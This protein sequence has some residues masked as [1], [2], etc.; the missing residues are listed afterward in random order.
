MTKRN[1]K[2]PKLT[3][4]MS[5]HRNN[6][7]MSFLRT[8]LFLAVMTIGTGSAWGAL[9]NLT[10][11][12]EGQFHKWTSVEDNSTVVEDGDA[13]CG[14]IN[15]N[16]YLNGDG[17][18][19]YGTGSVWAL[20]YAKLT[21]YDIIHVEGTNGM[22]LRFLFNRSTDSSSDYIEK[23]AT[24]TDGT[25]DL[26]LNECY[27][28]GYCHLNVI[29]LR[30]GS[31]QITALQA[32]KNSSE[33]FTVTFGPNHDGWGTVTA[34]RLDT[35]AD[36]TSGEVV[37]SGTRVQ[38][39][40]TAASS[41]YLTWGWQ[42]D[43][44]EY[45]ANQTIEITKNTNITHKFTRGYKISAVASNGTY[46][47]VVASSNG[48]TGN[49]IHVTPYPYN[50]V[51][52]KA[53]PKSGCTLE[54]WYYDLGYN[55]KVTPAT[56]VSI[57]GNNVTFAQNYFP[58]VDD[59]TSKSNVFTL[60]AKFN[61]PATH[62][63]TFGVVTPD[64]KPQDDSYGTVTATVDGVAINTGDKVEE[65]KKVVFTATPAKDKVAWGWYKNSVRNNEGVSY[66]VTVGDADLT[67]NAVI[68]D[69][70]RFTADSNEA[71]YGTVKI[72]C[73]GD[74]GTSFLTNPGTPGIKYVATPKTGA[75]FVGWFDNAECTGSAV[76]TDAEYS[77][78][79]T[80][81]GLALYA[82]YT[83]P[84]GTYGIVWSADIPENC[85]AWFTVNG[86][87]TQYKES[88]FGLAADA[89]IHY[90]AT[91]VRNPNKLISNWTVGGNGWYNNASD[92][93]FRINDD[94]V[95]KNNNIVT[96]A[97]HF[98]DAYTYKATAIGGCT[99]SVIAAKNDNS[100]QLD[101]NGKK[102]SKS[103]GRQKITL[104]TTPKDGLTFEGWYE[105]GAKIEAAT[106]T[107]EIT[108]TE[109]TKKN[110]T[111]EARYTIPSPIGGQRVKSQL[112]N[113]AKGNVPTWEDGHLATDATSY[114]H[115]DIFRFSN[116]PD[117]NVNVPT[118]A[119]NYTGIRFHAKA[120]TPFRVLVYIKGETNPRIVTLNSGDIDYAYTWSELGVPAASIGNIMRICFAGQQNGST[121][122]TFSNVWV[123]K[124][125]DPCH[126]FVTYEDDIKK[127]NWSTSEYTYR[128]AT[129]EGIAT[130]VFSNI[131]GGDRKGYTNEIILKE[132]LT[133]TAP[134][135]KTIKAL[136]IV[137]DKTADD[138]IIAD[139][140][141][142]KEK[143]GSP[144]NFIY[145]KKIDNGYEV[146]WTHGSTASVTI[147]NK[148]VNNK[149]S[150]A[151]IEV[152]YN[153]DNVKHPALKKI[154]DGQYS[155]DLSKIK[156]DDGFALAYDPETNTAYNSE[157]RNWC[158]NIYVE[159]ETPQDFST[160]TNVNISYTGQK[161]ANTLQFE[162]TDAN[163]N[164][165]YMSFADDGQNINEAD[166]AKLT[167]VKKI[168][169]NCENG[170]QGAMV[171]DHIK[172]TLG[173]MVPKV[174]LND[175]S[176]TEYTI[177]IGQVLSLSAHA[178]QGEG[179]TI[180][181]SGWKSATPSD[182]PVD[183]GTQRWWVADGTYKFKGTEEGT[184]YFG[185]RLEQDC[186]NHGGASGVR[187]ANADAAVV[188]VHVVKNNIYKNLNLDFDGNTYTEPDHEKGRQYRIYVPQSV[189]NG[190]AEDKTNVPVVFSLH[191]TTNDNDP[192]KG[193]V[194]NFNELAEANKFIVVYPNG[195]NNVPEL[196]GRGWEATGVENE[197]TKFFRAIIADLDGNRDEFKLAGVKQFTSI[198][199]SRIYMT[200][201]SN[202]GMMAYAEANTSA[203]IFAAFG[204]ISG[205]PIN[206][207]HMRHHNARPVP[208]IHIHGTK[209]TFVKY[210]HMPT[211]VDN[212]LFRNGLSFTHA[213]EEGSANGGATRYK[214]TSY[215]DGAAP[216]IYYEIGTGSNTGDSGMG[217]NSECTIGEK[218][219]MQVMWEFL[220]SKTLPNPISN[221]FEFK[222]RINTTNNIAREHGW[223]TNTSSG[224]LAQYG[225]SGGYT[226]TGENVY[227]TIHLN[228]G[229]HSIQF[230]A[231][232]S[233][234]NYV[235]VK[236]TKL[237]DFEAFNTMGKRQ[238]TVTE[239]VILNNVAYYVRPETDGG[240]ISIP[241]N[242]G[243]GEYM[244]TITKGGKWDNTSLED[245][246]IVSG[247]VKKGVVYDKPV[248]TDFGGY[249]NYNNRLF[250][251]WNF[252]LSDGY[253]TNARKLQVN[254]D[255]Q[256]DK[257]AWTANLSNTDYNGKTLNN[258][259]VVFSNHKIIGSD[260]EDSS[261]D[262]DLSTYEELTYNGSYTQGA[263]N[264]DLIAIAAGLKFKAP[265]GSVKLYVDITNG[266]VSGAHLVVDENVKM[267]I[268]Y[269][270]NSYRNDLNNFSQ[271]QDHKDDFKNCMHHINR[272]IIYI[273][274]N[275]G[276]IWDEWNNG[277]FISKGHVK[278][279]CID[280]PDQEL[281]HN[282]GD[283]FV[284]G[285]NYNKADYMGKNGT[286]CIFRFNRETNIDRIGVNRNL[287]YSFYT[288]YISEL[289]KT[290][291]STRFRVVGSPTGQK[292]ANDGDTWTEYTGAIAMTYGGWQNSE[293]GSSYTKYN[294]V[295]TTD[296]WT[297]LGVINY[298]P[299]GDEI[300]F[301]TWASMQAST[302]E[303]K[304]LS[305]IDG[306]PVVALL[307]T[308]ARSGS[309]LPKSLAPQVSKTE[310]DVDYVTKNNK[311]GNYVDIPNYTPQCEGK[312]M[313]PTQSAPYKANVTP[314]S[315][316]SRGG[317]AKFEPSIPGVLNM[318]VVQKGGNDYYIADEFGK[319]VDQNTIFSRT[320]TGQEINKSNNCY[321][322]AKTDYVKHSL[323][324]E[325]GKTYYIFSN[326]AGLGIAGFYFEPY[327]NHDGT[328]R[329]RINIG[330][331]EMNLSAGTAYA[332]PDNVTGSETIYSP[333]VD[334]EGNET[335]PT[336][337]TIH[338]SRKAVKV[339]LRRAFKANQWETICL[340]YSMNQVQ[341]EQAFGEGTRVVLL[342]DIQDREHSVENK[343]TCTLICHENQDIIAGYPYLIRPTKAAPNGVVTIASLPETNQLPELVSVSS[344]G[345]NTNSYEDKTYGGIGDYT[346]TGHYGG[347]AT[348]NEGSYAVVDG[349]LKRIKTSG[350]HGTTISGYRAWIQLNAGISSIAL[351]KAIGFFDGADGEVVDTPT[352]IDEINID[353]MLE[354]NGIFTDSVTVYGINGQIVRQN[355]LNLN[356]L[357]K[358][359]YIVNGKKFIVK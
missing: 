79:S 348:V 270:E 219:S 231:S 53:T 107:Y 225:E 20:H 95:T 66:T 232:G 350:G 337:Y 347:K 181:W 54:G 146:L 132:N 288:E 143:E 313:V 167:S 117:G 178:T 321:R 335:D 14:E 123:E 26:Y 174:A 339:N 34:K 279:E 118:T 80:Q 46:G 259:T 293:G 280:L 344:Q 148:D 204:S 271:P 69:G 268:P 16:T 195:R 332:L 351:A 63:V 180:L 94:N 188:T 19:V 21:G 159:F 51:T 233:T 131:G 217:H 138:F 343:V 111:F 184:F 205:Y 72:E 149:A 139:D 44:T 75:T 101:V 166:R 208:F 190:T 126:T 354:Q 197:D 356:D 338:Y 42:G 282:G 221:P 194:Q 102:I 96:L 116:V 214:M 309:L 151:K 22:K 177:G 152:I 276:S 284:N 251:Q 330:V 129:P 207:M 201:F 328:E 238:A 357:P 157:G 311:E 222:A 147:S 216:Y 246:T 291:P 345:V 289:G 258:G 140:Y 182:G 305:A 162:C 237:T 136:K 294:D 23:F 241:F 287:I 10:V 322:I 295:A 187:T 255:E 292:I 25:A 304:S 327:V 65:G 179:G 127:Y 141:N 49:D 60:W 310:N 303:T 283:E 35:N 124:I 45:N 110:R 273:A 336:P 176:K 15:L 4:G 12:G 318:N 230:T 68:H 50:G 353:K 37:P 39:I 144:T 103:D 154:A 326:T 302:A 226:T 55:N 73:S 142:G 114:N 249:F 92:R 57:D 78:T 229:D 236:V 28:N 82:K 155:L 29:K 32:V 30:G 115:V 76:S 83:V 119:D 133:I 260:L 269:V 331:R 324:V 84:E 165:N 18:L 323:N 38:F 286:P 263:T 317:Y 189:C 71:M 359:I 125:D 358:G 105:D 316:P 169:F 301:N 215:T 171:I 91:D 278:N 170:T 58:G 307:D 314:W 185:A 275:Q 134:A 120:T 100:E 11:G 245:V 13:T 122:V 211:I 329:G 252:D 334:A 2:L 43:N 56:N 210:S 106:A 121:D 299:S 234:T 340:P 137:T 220:S 150:I 8:I 86:G 64:N 209:D 333:A 320:G 74:R 97:P 262:T 296:A 306:F 191:G 173:H 160:L 172:F 227:H 41:N 203:D 52:F 67:V 253:R 81:T 163:N 33:G 98:V 88:V 266:Q 62:T 341:M 261:K 228:N 17:A 3:G 164:V 36:I 264:N 212:M 355:A 235:M 200:G 319:L 175:P 130:A 277:N 281:F 244:I 153:N 108:L 247:N 87:D 265:A 285:K 9:T 298:N 254:A 183:D 213:T 202:G 193:G 113:L 1:L 145:S 192:S 158:G 250:A 272:D 6:L 218:S 199:H 198:D 274:L 104:S 99:V 297:D 135:G 48:L 349:T 256:N 239:D 300:H 70:I 27:T 186:T 346:F 112:T 90:Q 290:K 248:N 7:V 5:V 242:G 315:L 342:R 109:E 206:E 156:A 40:A 196:W 308:E 77:P 93:T 61:P 59:D 47:S 243:E 161:V 223:Q 128:L 240:V 85:D 312:Y 352:G 168:L 325:P 89:S 31:G 267:Y 24:I 257:R 224:I